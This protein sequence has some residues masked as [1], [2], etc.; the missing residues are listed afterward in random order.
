MVHICDVLVRHDSKNPT[1]PETIRFC[2]ESLQELKTNYPIAGPLQ[3]MFR[4]SLAEN[5]MPV[6]DDLE[7]L[8]GNSSRYGPEDFL[9]TCTRASY[10][11]PIKQL[12]PNLDPGLGI[13]FV[14]EYQR[15][16]EEGLFPVFQASEG[17]QASRKSLSHSTDDGK[18]GLMR[19]DSLLNS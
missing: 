15:M 1:T 3:Q 4:L 7:S 10:R 13:E 16:E 2:F 8:I 12:L 17:S 19:I 18:Q 6:P 11:Q 14:Q 9:N 5:N